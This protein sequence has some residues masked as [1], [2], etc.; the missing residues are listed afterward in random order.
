MRFLLWMIA[1][2]VASLVWGWTGFFVVVGLYVLLWLFALL[3][4]TLGL[5]AIG[6]AMLAR[7]R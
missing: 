5:S 1:L 7:R 4:V 2:V 6:V 3:L